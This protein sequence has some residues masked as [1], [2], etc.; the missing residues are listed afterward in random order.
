VPA[1]KAYNLQ[2]MLLKI[3]QK[4]RNLSLTT[5]EGKYL[6]V[7]IIRKN[8]LAE[9]MGKMINLLKDL[10]E[11]LIT[12]K[13]MAYLRTTQDNF[14][15]IMRQLLDY[16]IRIEKL[17]LMKLLLTAIQPKMMESLHLQL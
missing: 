11:T 3:T 13:M 2:K 14:L 4:L 15:L 1:I 16:I 7:L 10:K 12:I 9:I 8:Y 17:S 6:R 5:L